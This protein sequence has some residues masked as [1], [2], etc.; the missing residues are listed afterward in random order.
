MEA[1]KLQA[2]CR[3]L[4]GIGRLAGTSEGAGRAEASVIDKIIKTLGAPLGGSRS[5]MG[6]T[7]VSGSLAS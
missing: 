6:E 7:S 5:R 2:V 1:I 4:R 3:Q